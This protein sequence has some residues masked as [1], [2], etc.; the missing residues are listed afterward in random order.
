MKNIVLLSGFADEISS[1]IKEQFLTLNKL[2]IGNVDVRGVNGKNISDLTD[3][4]VA[5]LQEE[6]RTYNIR[7]ACIGSP[8]GK[9][10]LEDPF[11][12]HFEKFVRTVKIAQALNTKYI[13]VFSFYHKTGEDWT[14]DEEDEVIYRLSKMVNYVKD[15]DIILLHENEKDVYGDTWIKCK[16]LMDKLYGNHFAAVFDPANFVQ[17]KEDPWEAYKALKPYIEYFHVK[18]ACFITGEVV[19]AGQGDGNL[20]K[21]VKDL[22][23]SDYQSFFS[24]EP[25][26]GSFEGLEKL[27]LTN[28]MEKLPRGGKECFEVAYKAFQKILEEI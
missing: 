10:D 7:A 22:I 14:R 23:K 6:M 11:E 9:V 24:L 26:L 16:K 17:C 1:E 27:E 21:I 4:E 13:R 15:T 18:D 28:T 2:N 19:P 12:N 20:F 8:I 5:L 3:A 25:H